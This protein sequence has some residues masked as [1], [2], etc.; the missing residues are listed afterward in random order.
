MNTCCCCSINFPVL[1]SKSVVLCCFTMYKCKLHKQ[2][3]TNSNPPTYFFLCYT[4][5]T[6]FFFWALVYIDHLLW[7]DFVSKPCLKPKYNKPI[8][9][10][11]GPAFHRDHLK[12]YNNDWL[13]KNDDRMLVTLLPWCDGNVP[14]W[15]LAAC[16]TRRRFR[17]RRRRQNCG[18]KIWRNN[19]RRTRQNSTFFFNNVQ[20]NNLSSVY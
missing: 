9:G 5:Q 6:L 3:K 11:L 12:T 15:I 10:Q 20:Y 2:T 8:V 7:V 1:M 17:R 14:S 4:N 13:V 16:I 19:G 18:R